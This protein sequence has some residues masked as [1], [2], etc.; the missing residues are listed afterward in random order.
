MTVGKDDD[1]GER[2]EETKEFWIGP[3][4]FPPC[5][6]LPAAPRPMRLNCMYAVMVKGKPRGLGC[7][8]Y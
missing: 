1:N 4:I 8:N 3:L 5:C 2:K 6:L 7:I